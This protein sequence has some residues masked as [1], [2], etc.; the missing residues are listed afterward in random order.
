MSR[1]MMQNRFFSGGGG[2]EGINRSMAFDK[3]LFILGHLALISSTL[4]NFGFY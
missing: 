2:G 3:L 4:L 1:Q